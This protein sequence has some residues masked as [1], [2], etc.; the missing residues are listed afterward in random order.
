[1]KRILFA[2]AMA[3]GLIGPAAATEKTDV[4]AVLHRFADGFNQGDLKSSIALCTDD[5]AI[6][7]NFPP[8]EWHGAGACERWATDLE[9][10]MQKNVISD[11]FVAL[12][13]P[14]HVY[15]DGDRAYTVVPVAFRYKTKGKPTTEKGQLTVALKK[16]NADW[17]IAAWSWTDQ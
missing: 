11:G 3:I 15:V 7:D 1:M 12:G 9:S 13:K 16:D 6:I 17:R 8:H 2:I 4:V 10:S 5:A 14:K